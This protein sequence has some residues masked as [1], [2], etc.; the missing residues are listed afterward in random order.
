LIARLRADARILPFLALVVIGFGLLARNDATFAQAGTYVAIFAIAA[1]GLSVLLGNV[2]QI[3]VGQ[4]GFFGIG[5]YAVGYFTTVLNWPFWPAAA[6]GVAAAAVVGLAL[7]F[8]AL[9]FRGHYLAMAT[10]AFGLIAVGI[11]HAS[12]ALGGASGITNIAY[13]QLG[14]LTISGYAAYW[15]A[16]IV[17]GLVALASLN[18]LRGRTG[19]AFETIRNDELAA[20]ATGVPTRRYKILAFAY[21][22][23]LAAV[24]GAIYAS[25][26]GLVNPESVGIGL[27]IDLLLMVVLGGSGTISGALVGAALIGYLNVV[28][29]QYQNWREVAYGALVIVF[30][31][32]APAGIVGLLRTLASR[33]RSSRRIAPAV[34]E[35]AVAATVTERARPAPV[36]APHAVPLAVRGL[37]K[38]FGGLVAV[39]GVSFALQPGTLT[40]LIGPNG[41]GKTTLFNAICGI[42]RPASG[43][44]EIAGTDVSGRQPHQIA[45]LGVARTFQNAR[46]F[47][48]MTVLENVVAGALRTERGSFATDLLA[49]PAARRAE[50]EAAQRARATLARLGLEHLADAYAKDL[51][52]GDRR[53]VELARALAAQPWLLL[54]DEPAAGLNAQERAQLLADLTALRDAGTTLLLVEHDMQLV[55]AISQRVMVL[56]FGRLIADGAPAQ[57]RSDPAVVAAYLGTAS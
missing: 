1:I 32:A 25:F 8:I 52:F 24:A 9:R 7:G 15:F 44:V 26:L 19:R 38:R 16:W 13:P 17:A 50:R 27:S 41:A 56:E 46:L 28:G 18:L 10:L 6:V 35:N 2:R 42:G 40:S 51:P 49:L 29:H 55:M 3:S 20:E 47:G 12:S 53:R 31:V 48:E 30:V 11:F 36:H 4:A 54:V 34:P 43:R 14:A 23:A 45:A 37:T 39:D 5:A 22:G 21:A 33:A 57:V